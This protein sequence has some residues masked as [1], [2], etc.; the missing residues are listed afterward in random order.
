MVMITIRSLCALAAASCLLMPVAWAGETA[1]QDVAPGVAM[2]LVSSGVVKP[3]GTTLVAL[4]I[5]MPDST[6]TYWRVPGDTGF[7]AE[8]SFDGSLAVGAH[9][10][11]WPYPVREEKNDYLDYAYFGHTIL[12]IELAVTEPAGT[13]DLAAIVGICSDIC[14]PAQASF[15]LPIADAEPDRP[16]G[17]R[18]RQAL[19]EV[20]LAWDG[21]AEPFGAVRLQPGGVA[22]AVDLIDPSI[23]PA[24]LIAA[25]ADGSPLFGTPQKSPQENLVLLPIVGKNENSALVG[26]SVQLTFMTD[27]G[28]YELDRVVEPVSGEE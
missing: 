17:L 23:D 3:D 10:V 1:W 4:E 16:N 6:K 20:P 26:T 11:L 8:L 15:S 19:A 21:P 2:R 22:L 18:I 13:I 9:K 5:D 28:P 24:S 12:P 25:T 27:M 7:P 14:I